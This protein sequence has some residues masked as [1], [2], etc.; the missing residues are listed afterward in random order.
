MLE[1]LDFSTDLDLLDPNLDQKK[2][3]GGETITR[4]SSN[5]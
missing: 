4:C 2:F 5:A 1:K 3:F